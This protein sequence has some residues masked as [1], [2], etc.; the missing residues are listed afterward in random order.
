MLMYSVIPLETAKISA[1]PIIPILPANEVK[2]VR[3]FLVKRF[4]RE[5]P[6][7]VQ[8][9]IDGFFSLFFDKSCFVYFIFSAVISSSVSGAESSLMT[10]SS[11]R[12]I[13][14]EYSFAKS[15]L[16]VTIITRRSLATSFKIFI[17]CTLVCV[18][19]A[20]VGSSAKIISGLLTRARAIATRC[21]C[22]PDISAG[23]FLSWSPRPTASK[24]SF[25]FL[26]LSDFET[27]ERLKASSTF[28][29]TL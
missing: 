29:N 3:P 13:R 8:R 26:R 15:G 9:D 18:S 21:I 7:D 27:P 28:C 25:A 16:C 2:M 11:I 17:T 22:P 20:P 19:S 5:R 23:F 12:I 1:I 14:V 24:A 4:F 6:K 10:P